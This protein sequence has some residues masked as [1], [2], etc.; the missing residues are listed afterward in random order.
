MDVDFRTVKCHDKFEINGFR[1][2]VFLGRVDTRAW[3]YEVRTPHAKQW[4]HLRPYWSDLDRKHCAVL[5]SAAQVRELTT[6]KGSELIDCEPD[7]CNEWEHIGSKHYEDR[8]IDGWCG[9]YS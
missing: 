8:H 2:E 6:G 7:N 1:I 5:V 4:V 9:C 3:E